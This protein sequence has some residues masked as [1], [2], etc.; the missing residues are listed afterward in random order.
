MPCLPHGLGRN[1]RFFATEDV[2]PGTPVAASTADAVKVLTSDFDWQ[3]ERVT[4]DDSRQTR[5]ILER[6]TRRKTVSWSAEGYLIPS[7]TN[8]TP[9]DA[10]ML[11]AA[12][13]GGKTALGGGNADAS[14]VETINGG[15]SVVYSLVANQVLQT[16]SL[17]REVNAIQME[18]LKGAWVEGMTISAPGG[19]EPKI[20]FEGG[21]FDA[22]GTGNA[23]LAT[24]LAGGESAFD[25]DEADGDAFEVGSVVTVGSSGPHIVTG[26]TPATPKYA[27]A[28]GDT[29]TGA[30]TA[31]TAEVLPYIPT[32]TTLGNPIAGIAGVATFT[33]TSE[34]GNALAAVDLSAPLTSFELSL[35]NNIKPLDDEAFQDAVGCLIPMFRMVTGTIGLRGRKDLVIQLARRK[36]FQLHNL[37]VDIG[38]GTGTRFRVT[39]PTIELDSSKLEIPQSDEATFSLP[40]T[41]LGAS[42]ED[43]FTLTQ[44]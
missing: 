5:S 16:L 24:T 29:I 39:L 7:G 9:P 43:E 15:T 37:V 35:V 12:A 32:E 25:V 41:A 42:G 11:I 28:I 4:R 14:V 40:F 8:D 1:L 27:I 18:M 20:S 33:P 17:Y 30:Q 6:I 36:Q 34:L 13:M 19:D 21:A 10:R 44:L 3:Q 26:I 38:S 23:L 22:V 31:G 2:T